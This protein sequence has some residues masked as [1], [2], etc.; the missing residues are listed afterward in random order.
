MKTNF[1]GK[2]GFTLIEL[3]IAM[4]L[5]ALVIGSIVAIQR[6]LLSLNLFLDRSFLAQE[7]AKN[8]VAAM[9]SELRSASI[10]DTGGYPLEQTSGNSIAFYAN[11]DS[12]ALKERVHYFLD[13]QSL[14]KSIVKPA[15]QPITY[16]T[17]TAQETLMTVLRDVSVDAGSSIFSYYDSNYAGTSTP[18]IQPV[19]I[20]AVRLIAIQLVVD[21][22]PASLPP[23]IRASS[24][25]NVRNLK[26]NL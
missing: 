17:T 12:D 26:S 9:V 21:A 1:F 24:Q 4:G 8:T 6:D 5:L 3:L 22:D 14:K 16:S 18:L 10:S 25:V 11:I 20:S 13:G 7:E 15:G 23:P 2:S 19:D